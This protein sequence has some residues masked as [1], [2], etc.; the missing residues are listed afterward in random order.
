MAIAF[1]TSLATSG[2]ACPGKAC[3]KVRIEMPSKETLTQ[4]A[5]QGLNEY[6][7][8]ANCVFPKI[9]VSPEHLDIFRRIVLKH[10]RNLID[11]F[12]SEHTTA[13]TVALQIDRCFNTYRAASQ[14]YSIPQ[15]FVHENNKLCAPLLL[16]ALLKTNPD[17]YGFLIKNGPCLMLYNPGEESLSLPVQEPV[18]HR[19]RQ[20]LALSH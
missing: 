1:L 14:Q 4:H 12:A 6:V 13:P 11:Y 7:K 2:L 9:T 3:N 15:D 19:K 5:L 20:K 18:E 10:T 17:E 16:K 8:A